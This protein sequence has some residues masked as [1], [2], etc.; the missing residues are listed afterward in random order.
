MNKI[1][2]TLL[3]DENTLDM[4]MTDAQVNHLR[5]LLAWMR[6]EYMLDEYMQKGYLEG[7]SK[8]V[9]FDISISERASKLIQ[10]KVNHINH[11]P[12]YIRQGIKM[13]TKSLNDHD[14]KSGIIDLKEKNI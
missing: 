11:V 4:P 12:L 1:N 9:E 6:V 8:C 7:F 3:G 2:L 5:R 13:L 10:D 14:K